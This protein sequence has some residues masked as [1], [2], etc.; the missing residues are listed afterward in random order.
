[1]SAPRKELR[2]AEPLTVVAT[3]VNASERPVEVREPPAPEYGMLA[4]YVLL[5]SDPE[6]KLYQPVVRRDGRGRPARSLAPGRG[7]A[8]AFPVLFG[9]DGWL[10]DRVGSYRLWAE[11]PQPEG[12][13]ARSSDLLIEVLPPMTARERQ[14]AELFMG[15]EASLFFQLKG[16]EHLEQ[17]TRDLEQISRRYSETYVAPY[18]DLALGISQSHSAFDPETKTFREPDYESAVNQLQRAIDQIEDPLSAAQATAALIG[19]LK[20][21]GKDEDAATAAR[22]FHEAHPQF[23]DLPQIS[24]TVERALQK[25]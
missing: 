8:E 1:L 19:C 10:L 11:Y 4:L 9:R 17:G 23:A 15:R 2:L 3:L 14:A 5:D 12:G 16:G 21:L 13:R 20:R 24:A 18:A 25:D 6:A 22:T 7:V